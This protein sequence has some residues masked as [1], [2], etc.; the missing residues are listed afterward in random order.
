MEGIL[1]W[2]KGIIGWLLIMSLMLQCV[3]G[4]AYRS[5]LRLFMGI[6]LILTVLEPFSRGDKMAEELE[7]ILGKLAYEE[8][9]PGWKDSSMSDSE[10]QDKLHQGEQWAENRIVSLAEEMAAEEKG[11]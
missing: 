9:V 8:T 11:E 10:W 3:P 2:V 1:G 4:K 5:Y 6:I 7:Q